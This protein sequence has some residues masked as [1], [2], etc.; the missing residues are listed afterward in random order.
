MNKQVA[1]NLLLQASRSRQI[2]T[3]LPPSRVMELQL[4]HLLDYQSENSDWH[5]LVPGRTKWQATY[6]IETVD[7]PRPIH[8]ASRINLKCSTCGGSVTVLVRSQ[9][10]QHL[11]YT[12]LALAMASGALIAY[13]LCQDALFALFGAVTA[14]YLVSLPEWLGHADYH[15]GFQLI[16]QSQPGHQL[17]RLSPKNRQ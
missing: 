8:G 13:A 7:L 2:R 3:T 11:Y 15:S 4:G 10:A 1:S 12:G 5:G 16:Q 6:Q 9:S 17:W 14:Y